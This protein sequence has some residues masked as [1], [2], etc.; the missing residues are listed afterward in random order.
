M[1]TNAFIADLRAEY[2]IN[3]SVVDILPHAGVRY[4]ALNTESYNL[5]VNGSTLNSVE[6]DTQ[7]IVQFPIGVTV[8][9]DIDVSGWNVK[10]QF[11]VSVIPAAGEKKN[12][13]KVSYTGI[14]AV[15]SVNTRIM[16]STSW[17]AMAGLQAE[18]GN[19]AIG[20]NYG[21][22]ASRHET[23]QGVRFTLGWKF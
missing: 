8:S 10:P 4:T 21:I 5:E 3:T 20:L 13:T 19:F 17:A 7:H 16:D 2:Q 1:D 22:Q 15:D 11:D 14:D 18:K 9:K 12:T 23:D 6:S